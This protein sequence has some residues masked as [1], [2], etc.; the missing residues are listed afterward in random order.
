LINAIFA[1]AYLGFVV[2][3]IAGTQSTRVANPFL[4]AFFFSVQAFTTVGF[5]NLAPHKLGP[6]ALYLIEAFVGLISFALVTG[7]MFARFS[8]PHAKIAFS[9]KAII[10]PY[11]RGRALEF[12]IANKRREQLVNLS[13]KAYNTFLEDGHRNYHELKLE[14]D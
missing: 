1:L 14:R 8:R 9:D 2:H 3:A 4:N 12:R 10:A 5:E 6:N 11:Q 7:F 13:V